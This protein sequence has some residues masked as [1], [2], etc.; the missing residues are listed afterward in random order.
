M[1]F[2][3]CSA[4]KPPSITLNPY[5]VSTSGIAIHMVSKVFSTLVVMPHSGTT[6]AI[7]DLLGI[8]HLI[9]YLT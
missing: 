3:I 5:T 7:Q 6:L 9:R 4:A 8:E 1:V 2:P